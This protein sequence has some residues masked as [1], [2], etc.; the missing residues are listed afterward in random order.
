[1]IFAP[2]NIEIKQNK[3]SLSSWHTPVYKSS[4]QTA[5]FL[6]Q[7]CILKHQSIQCTRSRRFQTQT[8]VK[9]HLIFPVSFQ[10]INFIPCSKTGKFCEFMSQSFKVITC[11]SFVLI[12]KGKHFTNSVLNHNIWVIHDLLPCELVTL[13]ICV[14][15]FSGEISL[16]KLKQYMEFYLQID[17]YPISPSNFD[18]K[19]WGYPLF[20]ETLH[21]KFY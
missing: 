21:M 16:P 18:L 5:R 3:I 4:V 13:T 10:V 19:H 11:I 12:K 7:Q 9:S 17:S 8:D 20:M 14:R 1:M 15:N 6:W 2:N